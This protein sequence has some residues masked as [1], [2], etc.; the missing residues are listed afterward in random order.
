M[1]QY[2]LKQFKALAL[3]I[4][5]T[6]FLLGDSLFYIMFYRAMKESGNN[7][8][9]AFQSHLVR[10][11]AF[12]LVTLIWLVTSIIS[13]VIYTRI[14]RYYGHNIW[15]FLGRMVIV[16]EWLGFVLLIVLIFI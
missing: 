15:S 4:I 13:M 12:C 3:L 7:F 6:M 1:S 14:A 5:A 11:P 16:G 9:Q 8:I 2:R 10:V